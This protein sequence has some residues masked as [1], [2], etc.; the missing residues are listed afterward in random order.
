[1]PAVGPARQQGT[2]LGVSNAIQVLLLDILTQQV[3]GRVNHP[4]PWP[5]A[6]R[7]APG[8]AARKTVSQQQLPPADRKPCR[9]PSVLG[10]AGGCGAESK[11]EHNFV[12]VIKGNGKRWVVQLLESVQPYKWEGKPERRSGAGMC[13]GWDGDER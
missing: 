2:R 8:L 11:A 7:M 9:L 3:H 1:M 5:N 13:R 10:R 4:V 6:N 12:K